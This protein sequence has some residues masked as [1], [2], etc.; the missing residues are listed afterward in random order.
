MS[1][2]APT[3]SAAQRPHTFLCT[4]WA[5]PPAAGRHAPA[6]P[7]P[8]R[9]PS[10]PSP[11]A[12]PRSV[13]H[14]YMH[15]VDASVKAGTRLQVSDVKQQLQRG[16]QPQRRR[17]L[18]DLAAAQGETLDALRTHASQH[19]VPTELA[20]ADERSSEAAEVL[21]LQARGGGLPQRRVCRGA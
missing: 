1:V 12:P 17:E 15:T 2:V 11:R 9:P 3:C 16:G 20:S 8:V 21:T 5:C 19:R 10:L 13:G 14:P 4:C 6:H 7:P 18:D